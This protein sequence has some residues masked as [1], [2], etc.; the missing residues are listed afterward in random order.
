MNKMIMMTVAV[1]IIIGCIVLSASTISEDNQKPQ[2]P[3]Q[4]TRY[5]QEHDYNRQQSVKENNAAMEEIASI[6]NNINAANSEYHNLASRVDNLERNQNQLANKVMN[7]NNG[8]N[9][10]SR[11]SSGSGSQQ[12]DC[13]ING[14]TN[15]DGSPISDA[16]LRSNSKLNEDLA[17]GTKKVVLLCSFK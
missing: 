14:Y 3:E 15:A 16:E 5:E 13:S 9:N 11:N 17:S 2:Q 1:F 10:V 7:N 6:R 4:L 12:M 8:Y